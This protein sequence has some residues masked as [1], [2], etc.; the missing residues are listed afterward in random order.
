MA[1][2]NESPVTVP[3]DTEVEDSSDGERNPIIFAIAIGG[4]FVIIVILTACILGVVHSS[5]KRKK[6]VCT[7]VPLQLSSNKVNFIT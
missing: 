5:R 3:P 2:G 6:R 4:A 7:R 1:D